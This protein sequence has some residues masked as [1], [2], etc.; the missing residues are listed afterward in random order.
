MRHR[1]GFSLLELLICVAI[2]GILM[3]LYLPVLG[4]AKQKAIQ[5]AEK[6]GLRQDYIGKVADGVNA[7]TTLTS[8]PDREE[9]IEAFRHEIRVGKDDM[10]VTELR[11]VV[12]SE[13]EFRAYYNTLIEPTSTDPLEYDNN[14]NL[15]A[16]DT[17]ENTFALRPI[18]LLS[19]KEIVPIAW[20]FLSSDLSESSSGALGAEVIYTDSRVKFVRYKEAFPAMPAVAV[21][22]HKFMETYF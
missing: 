5:T 13:A 2:I 10:V 21:L 16:T 20:S 19:E 8:I 18:D 22:S 7:G 14:G 9:C 1:Q 15:V 17:E 4:K 11:Y 3:M 12:E 6:E